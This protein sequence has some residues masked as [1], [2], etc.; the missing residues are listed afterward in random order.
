MTELPPDAW[1]SC[2][3]C[4]IE[5]GL[6][7]AYFDARVA[8]QQ[9]FRCPNGHAVQLGVASSTDRLVQALS[10]QVQQLQREVAA[11]VQARELLEDENAGLRRTIIDQAVGPATALEG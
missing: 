9:E 4:G 6:A 2:A 10:A 8:D 5:F 1:V 3:Q 11:H 7:R